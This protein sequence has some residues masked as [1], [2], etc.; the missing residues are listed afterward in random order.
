MLTELDDCLWHQLATTFD[1]VGNSDPRFFDRFWFA[2]YAR[3]GS[4]ALQFTM[5]VYRNMNVIDGGF[6]LV[7]G[8]RQYNVRVSRSLGQHNV[9][10]CG[11]LSIN[12]VRPLQSFTLRV[13]QGE[14]VTG[15]LD[16]TAVA[17]PVE[18]Q[19]HFRRLNG[20]TIEDYQRFNQI[21]SLSGRLVVDGRKIVLDDWWACRDHS[22]GVRPGMAV[23]EVQ[24][25]P[26]DTLEKRGYLM[27]FLFFSAPPFSGT[28]LLSE[29]EGEFSYVSGTLFDATSGR[30]VSVA[31]LELKPD[32][33]PG[34][35]SFKSVDI[36]VTLTDGTRL[37]L[38]CAQSG[39]AIAMQGLGYSGGYDDRKGLG[40]WRGEQVVEQDVW[41][42][43][44]PADIVYPDER[45]TGPHW[46]RIQPVRVSY[47]CGE[48]HHE[49][50]GSLT[51]ILS[52]RISSMGLGV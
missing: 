31:K 47:A 24:T 34:T 6:V 8:G 9:V 13:Q 17:K 5:G 46:H 43:S 26:K 39:S 44:H 10:E 48:A 27:A 14:R 15:E 28:L 7:V 19:P 29:R 16:W 25:G 2:A 18:E 21:G 35:R 12:V 4:A 49:G 32:L 40:F 38:Q 45:K 30:S 52:G 23:A 22:W 41:D 51:L 11:P 37:S 42:V 20:R 50:H 3:D 36:A 33:H 1:H